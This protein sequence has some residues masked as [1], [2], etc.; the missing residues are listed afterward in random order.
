MYKTFT[1]MKNTYENKSLTLNAMLNRAIIYLLTLKKAASST[2]VFS[3][4]SVTRSPLQK[5]VLC[6]FPHAMLSK[7]GPA[8]A[9]SNQPLRERCS[10][11]KFQT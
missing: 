4:C 1:N 5:P 10:K 3:F 7:V 8:V 6:G 2:G 11:S 9:G